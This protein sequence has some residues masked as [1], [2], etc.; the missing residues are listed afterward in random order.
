VNDQHSEQA[1][2]FRN[3]AALLARRDHSQAEL[4]RKLAR[5]APADIVQAVVDELAHAGL[6]DDAR[7]AEALAQHRLTSGWGPKRII[8]D[9]QT[10]GVERLVIDETLAGIPP[11]DVAAAARRAGGGRDGV[12]AYRRLEQRGFSPAAYHDTTDHD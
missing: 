12:A 3:A 8:H 11:D 4:A 10:A 5:H 7:F 6:V 1:A 2:A 9:L